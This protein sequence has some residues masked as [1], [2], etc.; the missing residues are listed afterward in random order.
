MHAQTPHPHPPTPPH[1]HI[2]TSWASGWSGRTPA[3]PIRME[4]SLAAGGTP[5]NLNSLSPPQ[6]WLASC[7]V[8]CA[9]RGGGRGRA[10][11]DVLHAPRSGHQNPGAHAG[12]AQHTLPPAWSWSA[13]TE[14]G[15]GETTCDI[16]KSGNGNRMRGKDSLTCFPC[17]EPDLEMF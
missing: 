4:A 14:R 8:S 11:A 15:T 17:S 2:L 12:V 9:Q 6:R 1:T 7:P 5:R 3:L 13:A 16:T 10:G